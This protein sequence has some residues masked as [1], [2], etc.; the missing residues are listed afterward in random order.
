MAMTPKIKIKKVC[1]FTK[2]QRF[3][4]LKTRGLFWISSDCSSYS[5]KKLS[6]EEAQVHEDTVSR[7]KAILN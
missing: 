7:P 3:S 6:A 4:F 5:D 2:L 1:S